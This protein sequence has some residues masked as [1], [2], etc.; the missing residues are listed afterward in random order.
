MIKTVSMLGLKKVFLQYLVY[1][2]GFLTQYLVGWL[3]RRLN[4]PA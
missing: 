4:G 2:Y 1:V 3:C